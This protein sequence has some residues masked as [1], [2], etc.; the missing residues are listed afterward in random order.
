MTSEKKCYVFSG[1]EEN[2]RISV[3]NGIWGFNERNKEIW[4]GMKVGE[5]LVFYVTKPIMK[6]I[7]FGVIKKRFM[8]DKPIWEREISEGC[9]V[10]NYRISFDIFHI[11]EKWSQ[12]ISISKDFFHGRSSRNIIPQQL[13]RYL[14]TNADEK[15]K[16]NIID[17]V[18]NYKK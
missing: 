3:K 13:F 18:V 9:L 7:G 10:W 5:F 16:T 15:W 17:D 6:I 11:C 8:G 2:W 1:S 12:G 4:N 14:V